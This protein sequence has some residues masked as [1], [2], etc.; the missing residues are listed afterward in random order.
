MQRSNKTGIITYFVFKD[1]KDVTYWARF[2]IKK[3]WSVCFA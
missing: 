2:T 3:I 1:F